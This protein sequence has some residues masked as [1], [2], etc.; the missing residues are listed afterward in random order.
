MS[1]NF[2]AKLKIAVVR[3]IERDEVDFIC[4]SLGCKPIADIEAFTESR[5]GTAELLEETSTNGAKVC[6][7][8][9]VKGIAKTVS[10]MVRGANSQVL[11][12]A[13]R[14]LHDA[15]CVIRCL[16][17]RRYHQLVPPPFFLTVWSLVPSSLE[18]VHPRS[19]S[20]NDCSSTQRHYLATSPTLWKRLP[21][22]LR[23]AN[24]FFFW[25]S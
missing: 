8:T 18:V 24:F 22:L 21:S 10:I 9:G 20:P 25:F 1:L 11:E 6:K 4:K 23:Y 12:E 2:L 13:E 7:I 14:S 5:L 17:K 16:V 15:H 19:K 3:D